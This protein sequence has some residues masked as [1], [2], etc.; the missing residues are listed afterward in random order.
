MK[1]FSSV[2]PRPL[3]GG[4]SQPKVTPAELAAKTP[5]APR[6][7]Y[8]ENVTLTWGLQPGT[9]RILFLS[10]PCC[11][12]GYCFVDGNLGTAKLKCARGSFRAGVA[13]WCEGAQG[14]IGS[15]KSFS[16]L[17]PK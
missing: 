4:S 1:G 9:G 10:H 12:S 5:F 6:C 16:K 14:V 8:K 11:L 13:A 17:H 2:P 15:L 3:Q 7:C